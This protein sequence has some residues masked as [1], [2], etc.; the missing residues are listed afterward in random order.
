MSPDYNVFISWSKKRS[1]LAAHA[2]YDWLPS[3]VQAAKPWISTEDIEKGKHWSEELAVSLRDLRTGVVFV[4]PENLEE[5]WLNFEAGALS[6]T[7]HNARVCIF[8]LGELKGS[9]IPQPLGRFQ[10]TGFEK[11]DVRKLIRTIHTAVDRESNGSFVDKTFERMWPDLESRF[12]E[13][14]NVDPE[15]HPKARTEIEILEELLQLAREGARQRLELDPTKK[16]LAD[17]MPVFLHLAGQM[18]ATLAI[19][20][21]KGIPS[22]EQFGKGGQ[23]GSRMQEYGRPRNA[24]NIA[25]LRKLWLERPPEKQTENDLLAFYG[26]IQQSK[27]SLFEGIA[28]E[29]HEMLT[30]ILKGL[31]TLDKH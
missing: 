22:E 17:L 8:R 12:N 25:E 30:T 29:G 26:E 2:F 1:S 16:I 23:L 24:K 21:S 11:G 7:V 9:D 20:E 5:P 15:E 18:N 14:L 6:K 31:V 4:T 28:G 3:V 13:I 27:P 19:I 10:N